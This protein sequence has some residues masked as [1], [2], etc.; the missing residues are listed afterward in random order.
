MT[1][2]AVIGLGRVASTWDEERAKYDG[3]PLPHAHIGCM[4]EVPEIEIVGL[5]D[6]WPE[7]REAARMKWG[8]DALFEDYREMLEKTRPQIVSVCTSMK[9]RKDIILEIANGDYGVQAIWAEKPLTYSLA[10]ADEIIQAVR[11][12]NIALAVN[13]THRWRDA[14]TQAREMI[15]AGYIGDVLH[16]S[17]NLACDLSQ[18]GSHLITRLTMFTDSPIAWVAGEA[19]SD[20]AIEGD[21]DFAGNGYFV[22]RNGVRGD[23][24]GMRTGGLE[25]T[26]DIT[27]SEGMFRFTEDGLVADLWVMDEGLPGQRGAA[28]A[29]HMFRPIHKP[30]AAGV[31]ALYDLMHCIETGADSRCTGEDAREALEVAIAVRESHRQGGGRVDLPIE[32]RSLGIVSR[33]VLAHPL[34]RAIE[35]AREAA[36]SG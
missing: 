23:F 28:P 32:D 20:Q 9:P 22:C 24:R 1:R 16:V 30:R 5:C 6:T 14:F 19:E 10:D 33:E 25:M 3:W 29:R 35:L 17:G 21:D 31:H 34:P 11:K 7:Q 4:A 2:A 18:N 8:I 13:C 26:Y 27:G 12:A 36:K 15:D